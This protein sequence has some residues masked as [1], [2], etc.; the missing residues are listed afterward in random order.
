M[1][2]GSISYLRTGP[3]DELENKL[4]V[5]EGVYIKFEIEAVGFARL[6]F[7][8]GVQA[9]AVPEGVKVL[10]DAQHEVRECQ[11]SFFL[12][13]DHNYDIKVGNKLFYK[14]I[15]QKQHSISI[16]GTA[17][18]LWEKE[19]EKK[20]KEKKE[21][22]EKKEEE[23][24]L[25]KLLLL[26][27]ENEKTEKEKKEKKEK[28]KEKEE[29]EEEEEPNTDDGDDDDDDEEEEEEE[30]EEEGEDEVEAAV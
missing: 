27:K 16:Y 20:K 18:E 5:A 4:Y 6:F 13:W 10:R 14:F 17:K 26:L 28:E 11:G 25:R 7:A 9:V 3:P 19:K 15:K 8:N 2:A 22:K 21:R 29:E 30:E 23:K 1:F 12:S 24:L